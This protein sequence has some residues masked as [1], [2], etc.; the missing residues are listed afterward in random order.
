[1]CSGQAVTT[2]QTSDIE[3]RPG[4]ALAGA[5]ASPAVSTR[6][7]ANPSPVHK[8]EAGML[9]G[10][11]RPPALLLPSPSP[12]LPHSRL[13][14]PSFVTQSQTESKPSCCSCLHFLPDSKPCAHCPTG[15]MCSVARSKPDISTYEPMLLG[16]AST[17]RP[18]KIDVQARPVVKEP[19]TVNELADYFKVCGEEYRSL[20][21]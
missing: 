5:L 11:S 6:V 7:H 16:G 17:T 3:I 1:V 20:H 4:G 12:Q 14:T 18:P 10:P 8:Y 2:T 21:D 15:C 9:L 13:C 19:Q